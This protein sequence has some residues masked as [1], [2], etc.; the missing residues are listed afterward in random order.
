MKKI[1]IIII[2]LNVCW[3]SFSQSL[4]KI[5]NIEPE[6]NFRFKI[7]EQLRVHLNYKKVPDCYSKV[8]YVKF[9]LD[10]NSK[11]YNM[12]FSANMTDTLVQNIVSKVIKESEDIWDV[13][14]VKVANPNMSFLM[15]ILLTIF[16]DDC[17][18]KYEHKD[19]FE[20]VVNFTSILKYPPI[21]EGTLNCVSCASKDKFVGMVLSPLVVNNGDPSH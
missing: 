5:S 8:F 21:N 17:K 7:S 1:I 3:E 10:E 14:K 4:T 9:N 16:K 20:S 18:I 15:P 19:V 11:T 12:K 2:L 13:K 6:A